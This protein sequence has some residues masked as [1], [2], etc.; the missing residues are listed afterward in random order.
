MI[1]ENQTKLFFL[2]VCSVFFLAKTGIDALPF[3]LRHEKVLKINPSDGLRGNRMESKRIAG[4]HQEQQQIAENSRESDGIAKNSREQQRITENRMEQQRIA[5]NRWEQQ[6]IAENSRKSQRT[7]GN[8]K[9]KKK[10][11]LRLQKLGREFFFPF[12]KFSVN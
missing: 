8:L 5:G 12:F 7:A 11:L 1:N 3:A 10:S 2:F 6:R 4:N 9:T